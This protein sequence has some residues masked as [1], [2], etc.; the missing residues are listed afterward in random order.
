MLR[1]RK[2]CRLGTSGLGALLALGA[3]MLL[4]TAASAA[5]FSFS[6][7]TGITVHDASL[8]GPHP[9]TLTVSDK[10]GTITDVN[11]TLSALSDGNPDD[12]DVA[13]VGP[14]G[15]A[16]AFMSDACALE[17][18]LPH[19]YSFDDEG[20]TNLSD[21]GNCPAANNPYRPSNF[22]GAPEAFSESRSGHVGHSALRLRR[23]QP[24]RDLEPLR[25]GRH[26]RQSGQYRCLDADA[27]R[28]HR[29]RSGDAPQEVQE[30][31]GQEEVGWHR[32]EEVQEEVGA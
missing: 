11:I 22:G 27:R 18:N 12:I 3:L 26:G 9:S 6:N 7:S 1:R 16:V 21:I 13:L 15:V 28:P 32:S 2:G 19:D 17:S 5:A 25:S 31:E 23:H 29:P 24:Q 20:S 4:P 14:T 8:A 30:E 10:A